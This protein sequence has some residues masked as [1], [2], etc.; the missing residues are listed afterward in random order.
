M[1]NYFLIFSNM[2]SLE[3]IIG[4]L[5]YSGKMM[6][7]DSFRLRTVLSI[8]VLYLISS[9][10]YVP[11]YYTGLWF[12]SNTLYYLLVFLM[13][14]LVLFMVFDEP[15]ESI[16]LCASCGYLTQHVAAQI[17]FVISNVA[18][19]PVTNLD[20]TT[21]IGAFFS[22]LFELPFYLAIYLLFYY[23]FGNKTRIFDY[24]AQTRQKLVMLSISTLLIVEVLSSIRDSFSQ[25]SIILSVI[26]RIFSI[27][28]CL[29]IL[30]LRTYIIDVSAKE[31]ESALI[32]QLYHEQKKNYEIGNEV[33]ELINEKC[34]DLKHRLSEINYNA[35]GAEL[36]ELISLYDSTV[37]TG[38]Q[39]LDNIFAQKNPICNKYGIR[40]SPMIDGEA[41]SFMEVGDICSLF[42]NILD[43]AIEAVLKL[44]KQ[45]DRI[46]SIKLQKKNSMVVIGCDNYYAEKIS[47]KNGIPVTSKGDTAYHGFGLKSIKRTA[48]KYGGTMTANADDMFH[49][50]VIIPVL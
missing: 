28:C 45:N 37:R 2:F 1:R 39:T 29:F 8:L 24:D 21:A 23:L 15:W 13:S 7:R 10:L 42:G 20:V 32:R 38:N 25:E 35:A 27:Q 41:I 22:I 16:M 36:G 17:V 47:F 46:I 6:R 18:N 33:I 43:N 14:V 44:D 19:S 4:Q 3:L 5:L 26:S 49:L 31:R 30:Y 50:T 34:H 48:Q 12:L 11:L 9:V 40:I